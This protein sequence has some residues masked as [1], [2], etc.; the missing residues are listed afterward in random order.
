MDLVNTLNLKDFCL[1]LNKINR[2]HDAIEN[3]IETIEAIKQY[4]PDKLGWLQDQAYKLGIDIDI[5]EVLKTV[6]KAKEISDKQVA[7][8][9]QV[10]WLVGEIIRQTCP[11]FI[12]AD[13]I[14]EINTLLHN[15][16]EL[17]ESVDKQLQA[18]IAAQLLQ[19]AI[20]CAPHS[21]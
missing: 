4:S 21:S 1:M 14:D 10:T 5:D 17:E 6:A 20:Q 18:P 13:T 3:C 8:I 12:F 19:L 9:R 15:I 16:F 2:R 11:T 7:L